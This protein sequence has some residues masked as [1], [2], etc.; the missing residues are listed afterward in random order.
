MANQV[1]N[2]ALINELKECASTLTK[3]ASD[4]SL[5]AMD[6]TASCGNPAQSGRIEYMTGLMH[7][8]GLE[9]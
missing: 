5:L 8:L 7:G 1:N 9:N 4:E 6:K 3:M 2:E